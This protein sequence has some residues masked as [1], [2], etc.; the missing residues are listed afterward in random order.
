MFS[1]SLAATLP[2]NERIARRRML[3]D[4]IRGRGLLLL[5]LISMAN[6]PLAWNGHCGVGEVAFGW[7]DGWRTVL[8]MSRSHTSYEAPDSWIYPSVKAV[9]LANGKVREHP[10]V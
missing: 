9:I 8:A 7:Q 6:A 5:F 3:A 4:L 10:H 2:T 1:L